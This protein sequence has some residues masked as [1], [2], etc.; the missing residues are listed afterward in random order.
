M[1]HNGE[2]FIEETIKSVLNQSEKDFW[3]VIRL[4]ACTDG[5]ERIVRKYAKK[6]RR[7]IVLKNKINY[8]T[9]DGVPGRNRAF[10][11]SFDSEY[12]AYLDHDD[13]LHPDFLKIL[14]C[15]GKKH[16]ADLVV[17]GFYFFDSQ[18]RQVQGIRV[19]RQ[20]QCQSME[21][22]GPYF[23]QLYNPLRTTWGKLYRA[24]LYDR[25]YEEIWKVPI[26]LKLSTDTWMVFSFL[27]HCQRITAVEQ[28]LLYYRIS[29]ESQF[30]ANKPEISRIYEGKI[31]FDKAMSF[32]DY[33][34]CKTSKNIE[35][36]YAVHGGHM[37]DLMNVLQN[38]MSMSFSEKLEYLQCILQDE[39]LQTYRTNAVKMLQN[40]IQECMDS[41]WEACPNDAA[42]W[43][44]YLYRL[45][46]V[47]GAE[48][49]NKD[50][51]CIY[52]SALAD[53]RNKLCYGLE[54]FSEYTWN[55]L[56]YR[57][58]KWFSM[59]LQK[60]LE[61]I[62]EAGIVASM[63]QHIVQ[64]QLELEQEQALMQSM[65]QDEWVQA[66]EQLQNMERTT[67]LGET[68]LF[69]RLMILLIQGQMEEA[70]KFLYVARSIVPE[71]GAIANVGEQM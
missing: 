14:Y 17:G 25:L 67:V 8:V 36:L 42:L 33:A 9:D 6:D 59:G 40:S 5:S 49:Y 55:G 45:W 62:R 64:T 26:Q 47:R 63:Y 50:I 71:S 66:F 68:G 51:L 35:I 16:D 52:I 34:H 27:E 7:I 29:Q 24:E 43:Q 19:P 32:L 56:P 18:T 21:E 38:S 65:E 22:L 1:V 69:C 4:N 20:M 57:E 70:Q 13:I 10:W 60:Q 31:L 44:Y 12:I 23:P 46:Y 3:Y 37:S 11:P 30:R 2:R 41:I 48:R 54:W 39:H 53:E 15:S 28:P 61:E 58:S